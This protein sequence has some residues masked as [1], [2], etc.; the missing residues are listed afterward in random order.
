VS[1]VIL[2]HAT[3]PRARSLDGCISLKFPKETR[4]YY[5]RKRNEHNESEWN[6]RSCSLWEDKSV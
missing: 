4:L 2:A 5:T 6:T 3:W 1:D